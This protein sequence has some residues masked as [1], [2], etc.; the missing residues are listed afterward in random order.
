VKQGLLPVAERK[1]WYYEEVKLFTFITKF[2]I[3]KDV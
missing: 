3:V 2:L 1:L